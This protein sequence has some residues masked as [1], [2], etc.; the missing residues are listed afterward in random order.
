MVGDIEVDVVGAAVDVVTSATTGSD[1]LVEP[2]DVSVHADN[3]I[4]SPIRTLSLDV[5]ILLKR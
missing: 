5:P 2:P 1:V 4:T 3:S